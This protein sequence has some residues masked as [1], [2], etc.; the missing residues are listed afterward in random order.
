MFANCVTVLL[1]IDPV[2]DCIGINLADR[3]DFYITQQ[4]CQ[5]SD[6]VEVKQ[7]KVELELSVLVV[8]VIASS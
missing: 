1:R 6:A 5:T 4:V 3:K 2:L 8:A 7:R